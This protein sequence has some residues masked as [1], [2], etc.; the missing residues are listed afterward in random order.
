MRQARRARV[1][2]GASRGQQALGA[3][4]AVGLP[5]ALGEQGAERIGRLGTGWT[6][7]RRAAA[8]LHDPADGLGGRPAQ[9]GGSPEAAELA[10]RGQDVQLVPR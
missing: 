5:H 3:D 2:G 7:D 1:P 4:P 10:V 9:A 6:L 8:T